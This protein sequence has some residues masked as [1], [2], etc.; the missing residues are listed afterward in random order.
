MIP[1]V[2]LVIVLT[3][4]FTKPF[5]GFAKKKSKNA[6]AGF[7]KKQFIKLGNSVHRFNT[8]INRRLKDRKSTSDEAYI[9][10]LPDEKAFEEGAN[11]LMEL[12][13]LYGL[14]IGITIHEVIKKHKDSDKL[15]RELNR[16]EEGINNK[17][18]SVEESLG[19]KKM[20]VS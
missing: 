14:T 1:V 5:L 20:L 7:F 17:V 13:F 2:K 16:L 18:K 19:A 6:N 9:K 3:K 8:R 4:T 11:F 15:E 10:D 12:I